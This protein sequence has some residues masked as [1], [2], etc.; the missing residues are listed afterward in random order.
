MRFSPDNVG[1]RDD[2][3]NHVL[4]SELFNCHSD[5]LRRTTGPN[6]HWNPLLMQRFDELPSSRHVRKVAGNQFTIENFFLLVEG[7]DLFIA[8]RIRPGIA[9]DFA[10]GTTKSG[11]KLS[12]RAFATVTLAT[13]LPRLQ[14]RRIGINQDAINIKQNTNQLAGWLAG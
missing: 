14:M 10:T 3:L 2:G 4:R 8:R 1:P 7:F 9:N 5:V 11:R 12:L 13:N 6:G